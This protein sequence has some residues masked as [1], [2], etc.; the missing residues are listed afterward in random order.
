[1][2]P[3]VVKWYRH[4]TGFTR[5]RNLRTPRRILFA[6]MGDSLSRRWGLMSETSHWPFG[7]GSW[8]RKARRSSQA[9]PLET[10]QAHS[11]QKAVGHRARN[12]RLIVGGRA[13][14]KK[15]GLS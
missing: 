13:H 10:P 14:T 12:D 9:V 3:T 6:G 5:V 8:N 7:D 4:S 11:A 1:M 2:Y 15:S